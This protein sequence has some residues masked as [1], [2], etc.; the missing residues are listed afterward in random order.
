MA[1]GVVASLPELN[2]Q[3]RDTGV[4]PASVRI[5]QYIQAVHAGLHSGLTL[6]G[7]ADGSAPV[8]MGDTPLVASELKALA[9]VNH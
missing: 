6:V 7:G 2:Q 3:L 9:G 1:L 4:V 5:T 8:A